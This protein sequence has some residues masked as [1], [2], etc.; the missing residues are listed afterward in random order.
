MYARNS[1]YVRYGDLPFF[2]VMNQVEVLQD[3]HSKPPPDDK[4][5]REPRCE[6]KRGYNRCVLTETH[7]G[8]ILLG[9]YKC[10]DANGNENAD[11]HKCSIRK[12]H[13]LDIIKKCKEILRRDY[14]EDK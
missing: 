10:T 6:F 9:R 8:S 4:E 3:D 2:G 5:E 7:D 11:W 12:K 1:Y 13:Y 14:G